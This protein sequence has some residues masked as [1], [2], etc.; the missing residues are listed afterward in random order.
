[1]RKS[2]MGIILLLSG[3]ALADGLPS[4]PS[5]YPSHQRVG[6]C[7]QGDL[8]E[9]LQAYNETRLQLAE[10]LRDMATEPGASAAARSRLDSYADSLDKMRFSLPPPNPDSAA[11]RNFDF[12]LGM[13]LT[14]ITLFLNTED[15]HL[16]A[17]FIHDRDDPNSP[18]GQY[19]VRLDHSR[20]TYTDKLAASQNA[21]CG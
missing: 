8:G 10:I 5:D 14:S 16:A 1:M 9:R 21:A 11:F 19:L 17:R 3:T 13:L 18:L 20:S 4:V 6:S 12:R 7:N 15:E 2:L